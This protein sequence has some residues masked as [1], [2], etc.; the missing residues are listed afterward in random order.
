MQDPFSGHIC[1]LRLLNRSEVLAICRP[2][3]C[4]GP[5]HSPPS[6]ENF[7][8]H[9][10]TKGGGGTDPPCPPC[11]SRYRMK[12]CRAGAVSHEQPFDQAQYQSAAGIGRF[13]GRPAARGLGASV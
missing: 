1:F 6:C 11:D 10:Q 4:A 8:S 13:P 7:R 5:A 9:E 3:P 12:M 2:P